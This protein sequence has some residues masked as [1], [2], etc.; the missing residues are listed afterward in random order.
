MCGRIYQNVK[1]RRLSLSFGHLFGNNAKC[2]CIRSKLIPISHRPNWNDVRIVRAILS[3]LENAL[4]NEKTTHVLL[5]TE[6]CIPV[7]TLKE[8][9]RSVLLDEICPWEEAKEGKDGSHRT[10]CPSNNTQENTSRRLHWNQS[11]VDCYDRNS[12]RC[13][14]FDERECWE[15]PPDRKKFPVCN[16]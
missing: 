12:S 14:R 3:L 16:Y 15:L 11:Y 8:T 10:T 5:C 1:F 4:R 7:A 13:T 2:I 9:A 6:S